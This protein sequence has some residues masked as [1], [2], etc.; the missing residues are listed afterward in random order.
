MEPFCNQHQFLCLWHHMPMA[1]ISVENHPTN[2]L[3]WLQFLLQIMK[4]YFVKN[5]KIMFA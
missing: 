5:G 4:F 1:Q 3:F 2:T